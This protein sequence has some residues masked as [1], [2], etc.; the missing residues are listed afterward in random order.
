MD[1]WTDKIESTCTQLIET[2]SLV[3]MWV[4]SV[5]PFFL[6]GFFIYIFSFYFCFFSFCLYFL[7]YVN[8][9]HTFN[10]S[11][12]CFMRLRLRL[13]LSLK[14]FNLVTLD[15]ISLKNYLLF[16]FYFLFFIYFNYMFF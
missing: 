16:N 5:D 15:Y 7:L 8:M 10:C 13:R 4:T 12:L 6:K 2:T 9:F 3:E 11:L 14:G 1:F